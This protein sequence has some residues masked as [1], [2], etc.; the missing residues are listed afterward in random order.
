M[1]CT[2]QDGRKSAEHAL[3]HGSFKLGTVQRWLLLPTMAGLMFSSCSKFF[4]T[5]GDGASDHWWA[6]FF[7]TPQVKVH[8]AQAAKQEAMRRYPDLAVK[9]SAFNK[10]FRD[11]Y[12]DELKNNSDLLTKADWPVTLAQKTDQL[13]KPPPPPPS[14]SGQDDVVAG[15]NPSTIPQTSKNP[16]EKGSYNN[17][18]T[19]SYPGGWA[20][21]YYP[22]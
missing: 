2:R 22:H 15:D 6:R 11:V 12:A 3:S 19:R 4:Q 20:R 1:T 10:V 18:N 17:K 7:S 14:T 8:P 21:Y 5:S 16:L 9:D 13:L